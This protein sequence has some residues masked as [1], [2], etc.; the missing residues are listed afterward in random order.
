MNRKKGPHEL[1]LLI[2][3]IVALA[4]SNFICAP[5]GPDPTPV[6]TSTPSPTPIPTPTPE[7]LAEEE[8]YISFYQGCVLGLLTVRG[9][10]DTWDIKAVCK[11]LTL[12]A[13][14]KDLFH[15]HGTPKDWS[16]PPPTQV[17]SPDGGTN[18]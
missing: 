18:A 16:W 13:Y 5:S 14:W 9:E 4:V 1:V 8:Y 12:Q 17:P 3:A 10:D 6:P 2:F 15:E 7:F 11:V